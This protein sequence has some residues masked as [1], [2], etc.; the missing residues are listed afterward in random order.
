MSA[1]YY[2]NLS[3]VIPKNGLDQ[4]L[5]NKFRE[6]LALFD[7]NSELL[8][9]SNSF[10][11]SVIESQFDVKAIVHD[12]THLEE[13]IPML[14]KINEGADIVIGKNNKFN[15]NSLF[16]KILKN[17]FDITHD[18]N[19]HILVCKRTVVDRFIQNKISWSNELDLILNAKLAGYN[20]VD[21]EYKLVTTKPRKSIKYWLTILKHKLRNPPIVKFN[22]EENQN[23]GFH[24]LGKKYVIYSDLAQSQSAF[25]RLSSRQKGILSSFVLIAS[26]FFVIDWHKTI[27]VLMSILAIVYF[28]D[29]LFNLYLIYKSFSKNP[30]LKVEKKDIENNNE[31]PTYTVLCPLYKE[32]Q[33]LEQFVK[34]MSELE[35]P[36]EKLQIILLLEEDD[37]STIEHAQKLNL[38]AEFEIS[39]LPHS[40]PKTKPKALNYGLLKAK[41]EFV[42]IYDAEDIPDKDQLKKAVI[43][44]KMSDPKTVCIQAKLNFYNPRQNILTKLFAAE[45][46]LWFDLVLT[47]L[48][49]IGAPI[50]LGGTS[51]HFRKDKISE[52]KGWDPFNVT[53]DCDLGMRLVKKGYK[54]AILDSNTMEEANS[55][56]LNWYK[57]RTRWIK[58]YIQTYLVHMRKPSEFITDL[59]NPNIITFQLVVGGKILS[60]FVNPLMWILT[61]SY[62]VFR[63][64]IGSTIES[65]FPTNIFYL[66]IFSLIFGNFLYMYYYMIGC[67][68]RNFDDIMKYSIFIPI[69]WLGMSIAAFGA[70]WSF[71]FTPHY[72][73]KTKHGMHLAKI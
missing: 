64:T 54:T 19:T 24:H 67:V 66:S 10:S 53:E 3:I 29:L 46:A 9:V 43:G 5:S 49:S 63:S 17:F 32:A 52:L 47:G 40:Y 39:I 65:F 27:V 25:K 11:K 31:W 14:L 28:S 57:Q 33:V 21:H 44:F 58:G 61:I 56:P 4:N 50:P 71:I 37:V 51:N 34:A 73:A 35:Y 72:W 70:V 12:K 16:N 15:K 60:M 1:Q 62:F 69:Y 36:K 8:Q 13:V 30:D 41:G 68:K 59:K 20:I 45:Y 38:P 22:P 23:A 26:P 42:V 6:Q 7:I 48:Q 18:S 2:K 55:R